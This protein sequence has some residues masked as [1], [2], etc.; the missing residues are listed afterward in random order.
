MI[1]VP[2]NGYRQKIVCWA[3]VFYEYTGFGGLPERT[4]R[5]TFEP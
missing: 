3:F 5:D 1:V 4:G 2:G